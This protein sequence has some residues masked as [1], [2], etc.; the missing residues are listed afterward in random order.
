M[1]SQA[2]PSSLW[3]RHCCH[4]WDERNAL[5]LCK[6]LS[7]HK[8][9]EKRQ[10]LLE[11][12]NR[13]YDK[14]GNL[15]FAGADLTRKLQLYKQQQQDHDN[16]H[17]NNHDANRDDHDHDHDECVTNV[18]RI[19]TSELRRKQ[20]TN[21]RNEQAFWNA[22]HDA[23]PI[24][25]A[26]T[27]LNYGQMET[28]FR[29]HQEQQQLPAKMRQIQ[30]SSWP[31]TVL[32]LFG[33]IGS[34]IVALK[35]LRMAMHKVIHVEHDKVA[36]H[37]HHYNHNASYNSDLED[38]GIEHVSDYPTFEGIEEDLNSFMVKHAPIDIVLGGPPCV[39]YTGINASR[40]GVRGEQGQYL[41][42]FGTLVAAIRDHP[43]QRD[44][45]LYFFA[46]NV[47]L[48]GR[49][50][51]EVSIA[52]DITPLEVDAHYFSPCRRK[53]H[54]FLNYP[55]NFFDLGGPAS[56]SK[57]SS[58]LQVGWMHPADA[59]PRNNNHNTNNNSRSEDADAAIQAGAGAT[60]RKANTF[61]ASSSRIDDER[62]TVVKEIEK[63]GYIGRSIMVLERE[64]LMGFPERYV[65]QPLVPLFEEVRNAMCKERLPGHETPWTKEMDSKYQ[66]FSGDVPQL[67]IDDRSSNGTPKAR[68]SPPQSTA[69]K[70]YFDRDGYAKRLLGNAYSV[71]VAELL[72][73][74]LSTLY[75]SRRYPRFEYTFPWP[76]QSLDV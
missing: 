15:I 48:R 65:A 33:G 39:D 54:F 28:N 34:G 10:S 62:M 58:C 36:N 8:V 2:T 75:P 69:K 61:M 43:L 50:L 63:N 64:R 71:V 22:D 3:H 66:C 42:R 35:R 44:V 49:D 18:Q 14:H 27:H 56:E 17:D 47:I 7:L 5:K 40:K 74:P 16:D 57:L 13:R 6:G 41:Q 46:E 52:F 20:Q 60:L 70:S 55:S 21:H 72:L 1:V 67:A 24:H 76:H 12:P 73:H 9:N 53:R 25:V 38:D 51:D 59:T 19:T 23:H 37:V 4:G 11:T 45:P 26:R 29:V 31:A 30:Y 32:D 68:L